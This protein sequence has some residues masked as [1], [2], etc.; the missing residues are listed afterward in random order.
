MINALRV[1]SNLATSSLAFELATHCPAFG[2]LLS[3]HFDAYQEGLHGIAYQMGD[4]TSESLEAKRLLTGLQALLSARKIRFAERLSPD[5]EDT[6]T[7][8]VGWVD[9][10]GYYLILDMAISETENLYRRNGG[11]GGVSKQALCSQFKGLGLVAGSHGTKST[12]VIRTGDG[13]RRRV[14]H[15]KREALDE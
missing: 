5:T 1:A 7:T 3:E 12:K 13:E 6:S 11:L 4:Y 9:E 14:L 8:L 10:E 2:D 15:L